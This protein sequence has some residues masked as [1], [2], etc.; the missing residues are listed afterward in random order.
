MKIEYLL[1]D[2][3]AGPRDAMMYAISSIEGVHVYLGAYAKSAQIYAEALLRTHRKDG[4]SKI[5][6]G[7]GQVDWSLSLNDE[8]GDMAAAAIE[9][10]RRGAD[11]LYI[12]TR[13]MGAV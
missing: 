8:A 6:L 13:A 7:E 12:I 3:P 1:G 11:G 9:Y 5:E 10:G 2:S 4:D